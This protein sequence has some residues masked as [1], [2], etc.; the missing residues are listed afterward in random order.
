MRKRVLPG[1]TVL[2][3]CHRLPTEGA[4]EHERCGG[5][6]RRGFR[7]SGRRVPA[8]LRPPGEA[9]ARGRG[10]HPGGAGVERRIRRG[11]HRLGGTGAA[12][13]QARGGGRGGPGRGRAGCARCDEG[14]GGAGA[15]SVV[16]PAVRAA[17]GGGHAAARVRQPRRQGAIADGGVRAGSLRDV[18]SASGRRHRGA[19]CVS[20]HGTSEAILPTACTAPELRHRG[21]RPPQTPWRTS[22]ITWPVGAAPPVRALHSEPKKVG[23]FEST[24]GVL[25]A[26]ALTPR[27]S[28]AFIERLLGEQ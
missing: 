2:A 9:A 22:R 4:R 23:A 25:R 6:C 20:A 10:A 3:C 14:G 17:G 27:E 26:Q 15:V 19:A 8:L 5:R 28:L 16:L 21:N 1:R 13:P 18:A 24:Y 11:A 7:R 12:H